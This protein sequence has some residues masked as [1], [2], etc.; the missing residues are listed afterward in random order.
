MSWDMDI[1]DS[2]TI[3]ENRMLGAGEAKPTID[4]ET[5]FMIMSPA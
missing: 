2:L 3:D 1:H 5:K 4:F